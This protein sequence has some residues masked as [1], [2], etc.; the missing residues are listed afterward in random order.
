MSASLVAAVRE[1]CI[2]PQVVHMSEEKYLEQKREQFRPE[3][4]LNE[5]SKGGG[6]TGER[7]LDLRV[8]EPTVF[9]IVLENPN[10]KAPRTYTVT[11]SSNT[12]DRVES[13]VKMLTNMDDIEYW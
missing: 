5:A 9:F 3:I 8:G 4:H 13:M 1:R 7:M 10:E 2:Q 12:N 6:I 11:V